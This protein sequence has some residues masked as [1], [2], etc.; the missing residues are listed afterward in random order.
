M[1]YGLKVLFF[2]LLISVIIFILSDAKVIRFNHLYAQSV[3]KENN[4]EGNEELSNDHDHDKDECIGE[5]NK[6]LELWHAE[7]EYQVWNDKTVRKKITYEILII[8]IINIFLF[9]NIKIFYR[10]KK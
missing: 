7:H 9:L 8:I 1:K 2:L 6:K 10:I 5:E 3:S 4:T